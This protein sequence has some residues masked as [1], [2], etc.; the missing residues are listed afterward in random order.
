M[1][2][3]GI[4]AELAEVVG[5]EGAL[6]IA[7][8]FGGQYV[9]LSKLESLQ[10]KDRNAAIRQAFNGRNYRELA[11]KYNLSTQSIRD[12][13]RDKPG[14]PKASDTQSKPQQIS[15]LDIA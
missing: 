7:E 3:T 5:E 15:L 14:Q 13:V 1:E 10:R 12:I 6:A 4:Y 11:A 8:R 2:L 9:Y